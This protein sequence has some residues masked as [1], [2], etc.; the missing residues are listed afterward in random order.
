MAHFEF[1]VGYPE[2]LAYAL[3]LRDLLGL[4][5]AASIPKTLPEVESPPLVTTGKWL[6]WWS[7]LT[8]TLGES[9]G[10]LK[11]NGLDSEDLFY[12]HSD[13]PGNAGLRLHLEA[14]TWAKAW[15]DRHRPDRLVPALLNA[16]FNRSPVRRSLGRRLGYR[17]PDDLHIA[18]LPIGGVWGAMTQNGS[19]LVSDDIALDDAAAADWLRSE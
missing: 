19:L 11:L 9:Q 6:S 2:V 5:G 16:G 15:R 12:E 18:V 13:V 3:R 4:D 8:R 7:D 1:T 10:L 17:L 14:Q